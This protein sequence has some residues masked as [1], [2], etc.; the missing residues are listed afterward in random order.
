MA[1]VV[2]HKMHPRERPVIATFAWDRL[3]F[4]PLPGPRCAAD[5]EG[6]RRLTPLNF[7]IEPAT[8]ARPPAGSTLPRL[9]AEINALFVLLDPAAGAIG[10]RRQLAEL[11]EHGSHDA[12]EL[13]DVGGDILAEGH[14]PTL[15]SPLADALAL[16]G[17]ADQDVPAYITVAGPGV[18]GELD[19]VVMSERLRLTDAV[20]TH[21]LS[22][23]D[24][25]LVAH[26]LSWHPSEATTLA[27]AAAQGVRGRVEIRA[28]GQIV[29][30]TQSSSKLYRCNHADVLRQNSVA[31]AVMPSATLSDAERRL[32]AA[33]GFTELAYER[34]RAT[35]RTQSS[36]DSA[37]DLTTALPRVRKYL[38][39]AAVRG[40]T[41]V[42]FRRLAEIGQASA[43]DMATLRHALISES[44]EQCVAELWAVAP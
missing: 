25:Q 35:M 8:T 1:A 30:L 39:D 2:S 28:Q 15:R 17:A 24:A 10:L 42:T 21:R 9:A 4:D 29:D 33:I 23:E 7:G 36:A 26:T 3:I 22:E 34:S 11:V 14:E 18:D 27:L 13:V 41:H 20:C 38:A 12:I 43:D 5:F 32:S 19:P 6:L 16:A 37:F 40:I 31:K 44:P